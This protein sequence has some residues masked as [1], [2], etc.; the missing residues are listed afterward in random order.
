[1]DTM[2][3]ILYLSFVHKELICKVH[4]LQVN[5]SELLDL[6]LIFLDKSF[7]KKLSKFVRLDE[8]AT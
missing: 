6:Q 4:F 5:S 3:E 1:M 7:S 8:V 2:Y